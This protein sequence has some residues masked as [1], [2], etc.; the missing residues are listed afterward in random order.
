MNILRFLLAQSRALLLFATVCGVVSGLAGARLASSIGA[1]LGQ[2]VLSYQLGLSFLGICLVYLLAKSGSEIALLHLTQDAVL[3]M[4]TDLSRKVLT[5][6]LKQLQTLGKSGLLAILT[7]DIDTFIQAFMFLPIAFGNSIVVLACLGYM[8]WLSWQLFGLF[9]VL[10]AVSL[11]AY[12]VAERRP[13]EQLRLLREHLDSLYQ[14]FR[15][16]I[17]GSKELQLNASRGDAFV[18]GTIAP[19]ARQFKDAFISGMTRYTWVINI[20]GVLFYVVIGL[21]VFLV[22]MWL[23]QAPGVLTSFTLVLLFLIRPVT[24]LMSTLPGLRQAGI[25]LGRIR[26]LDHTLD[27]DTNAPAGPDPFPAGPTRLELRGVA[28]HY[29]GEMGDG[30]FML[31][32]LELAADAGELVFIVGGNGSGKTTLAMLLLGLYEPEAGVVCLNGVP[33]TRANR[34]HYRQHFSAVFADFHLLEQ[35]AE[36]GTAGLG[37]RASAY[38]ERF[39]MAHKVQVRQGTFSTIKLSSGQRKRLALVSSY[40]EDRAIYLFDEWAADQDPA[41]KRVFYTELLPE[42]KARGKIV[43]VIS[44]DD[45]YFHVADR[46][47]KLAEGRLTET[48]PAGSGA[49]VQARPGVPEASAATAG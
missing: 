19:S 1:G 35:L 9:A 26:Q 7:K 24:E 34:D 40:L 15:D 18:H 38:L 36:A 12:H 37:E 25:A 29:P 33:V 32:P 23:P 44:H 28:H 13:V 48:A 49:A 3:R 11:A 14:H 8:A 17:E 16:L 30:R 10:L 21:L 45:A 22:P 6:P 43:F 46:I 20:G 47:V 39:G 27:T 2:G 31:G 5:T 42:L 41:F 4:R